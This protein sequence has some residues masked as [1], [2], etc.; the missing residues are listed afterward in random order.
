VPGIPYVTVCDLR[1]KSIRQ[2]GKIKQNFTLAAHYVKLAA[3]QGS[4]EAAIEYASLILG[5]HEGS[6]FVKRRESEG[7]LRTAVSHGNARAQVLLGIALVYGLVGRIDLSEARNLFESAA[8]SA[9]KTNSAAMAIILRDSLSTPDCDLMIG[10]NVKSTKLIFSFLRS[11]ANESIP[12]IRILNPHLPDVQQLAAP[13]SVV[14]QDIARF[15]VAYLIDLSQAES[16]VVHSDQF[17]F[18][19]SLS[20]G[21]SGCRLKLRCTDK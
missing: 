21:L 14:W 1:N 17:S 18:L 11:S 4:I 19:H 9:S 16:N 7:Y 6:V 15:A 13:D 2:G 8:Q 10:G 20:I 3:D 5:G 12:L